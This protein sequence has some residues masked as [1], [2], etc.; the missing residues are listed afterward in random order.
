MRDNILML[1]A[2]KNGAKEN[3]EAYGG[4]A[5]VRIIGSSSIRISPKRK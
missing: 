2:P 3:V 1:A 4:A 5:C